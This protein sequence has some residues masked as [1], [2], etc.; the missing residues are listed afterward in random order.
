[1]K[2]S[3]LKD[4]ILNDV[5]PEILLVFVCE[6]DSFIAEQYI[7]EIANRKELD[8]KYYDNLQATI[9]SASDF[10]LFEDVEHNLKV[11]HTD[12]FNEKFDDYND[13]EDCIV[14]CNKIDKAVKTKIEYNTV[15]FPKTVDWQV[16][17]YIKT[18]CPELDDK[19]VDAIYKNCN[20]SAYKITNVLDNI[21]LFDT[22]KQNA[23]ADALLNAKN[24]DLFNMDFLVFVDAILNKDRFSVYKVLC[25]KDC[26]DIDPI[27][28]TNVLLSKFKNILFVKYN[29][30]RSNS[31]LEI[32]D[33]YAWVIKNKINNWSERELKKNIDFLSSI[34]SRLKFGLLDV[35]KN[36]MLDYICCRL[37]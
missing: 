8:I 21:K 11:I 32:S 31:E 13:F 18:V 5:A 4:Y 15:V 24:T 25:H 36:Y 22:E 27:A 10:N 9:N 17:A 37:I 7:Q 29:S 14:V 33:K 1:M 19:I 35:D 20:G 34:D 12:I 30:G 28:L 26:C 23:V 3:D 6:G 2:L 16:K